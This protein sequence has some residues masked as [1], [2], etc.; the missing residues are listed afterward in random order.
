MAEPENSLVRGLTLTH[1]TSLIICATIGT[2][3]L[4]KT[5]IMAQ[6]AGSPLLVIAAWIIA[7]LITLTG[8]LT[9]AELGAMLPNAGGP[10]VY[11]RHA[12][13]NM[14]G[15]FLWLDDIDNRSSRTRGIVSR[16]CNMVKY[17]IDLR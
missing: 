11:V 2:G 8:A 1:S 6:T 4:M 16:F 17:D 14:P 5:S 9:V 15:V 12:F 10:Y 3:I 13:G 7:G